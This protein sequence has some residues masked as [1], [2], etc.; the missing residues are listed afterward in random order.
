MSV[1]V[2]KPQS[3]PFEIATSQGE[4]S[5]EEFILNN[6]TGTA[7]ERERAAKV[8][9]EKGYEMFARQIRCMFIPDD[10]VLLRAARH[11]DMSTIRRLARGSWYGMRELCATQFGRDLFPVKSVT[12]GGSGCGSGCG[13]G[14]GGGG[15]GDESSLFTCTSSSVSVSVD[16][17]MDQVTSRDDIAQEDV[18]D[19]DDM[20][21]EVTTSSDE[22]LLTLPDAIP[23]VLVVTGSGY[24]KNGTSTNGYYCI[25]RDCD[26]SPR[27]VYKKLQSD[28]T[29]LK[30]REVYKPYSQSIIHVDECGWNFAFFGRDGREFPYQNT[31]TTMRPPLSGWNA[32][33]HGDPMLPSPTVT[34]LPVK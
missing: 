7:E 34:Y 4:E 18:V 8:E 6:G 28:G 22:M 21:S 25:D 26:D 33:D 12:T 24:S 16:S 17:A 3:S 20:T 15:D 13:G 32:Q 9:E 23:T 2:S 1:P 29:I 27:V 19:T 31:A 11:Q 5:F 14:G 30:S 10:V